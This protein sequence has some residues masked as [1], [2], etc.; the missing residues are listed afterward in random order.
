MRGGSAGRLAERGDRKPEQAS[1]FGDIG[2]VA[3]GD[4]ALHRRP[5]IVT[6]DVILDQCGRRVDVV[7]ARQRERTPRVTAL[8]E[9]RRS[10][11]RDPAAR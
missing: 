8:H 4:P 9:V 6:D 11:R 10:T 1:P 7:G 5:R 2:T 3:F